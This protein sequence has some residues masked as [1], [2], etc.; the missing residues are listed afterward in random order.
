MDRNPLKSGLSRLSSQANFSPLFYFVR[1]LDHIIT[2][3]NFSSTTILVT[4]IRYCPKVRMLKYKRKRQT[5]FKLKKPFCCTAA[6][7]KFHWAI[8]NLTIDCTPLVYFT[9]Q[10]LAKQLIAAPHNK[11]FS[12]GILL[13]DLWAL[14]CTFFLTFVS[15]QTFVFYS[16]AALCNGMFFHRGDSFIDSR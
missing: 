6:W 9:D 10:L 1:L 16:K 8:P 2:F 4:R 12:F 15:N 7:D 5:H 11:S 3:Y 13:C 14:G